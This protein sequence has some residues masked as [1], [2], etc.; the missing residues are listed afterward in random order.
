MKRTKRWVFVALLGALPLAACENGNDV[1]G[2]GK[3]SLFLTDAPG[4]SIAAAVVTVTDV[5]LQ[6]GSDTLSES[7][8]VHLFTGERTVDLLTLRDSLSALVQNQTVPAGSYGQLRLVVTGAYVETG[9]GAIY[10]TSPTYAGLP[11]GAQVSGA[12]QAPSYAQSGL[13]I[14][15]PG[16]SLQVGEGE[17]VQLVLDFDVAQSFGHATGASGQW[18]LHPVVRASDVDGAETLAVTV[19]TSAGLELPAGFA[20]SAVKVRLTDQSGNTREQA[21]A[22]TTGGGASASFRYLLPAAGPFSIS[23]VA[24]AGI[25]L[26]TTPAGAQSVDLATTQSIAFTLTAVGP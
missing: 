2:D 7:S 10:A 9:S 16:G 26:Q 23:L 20:L 13:K 1:A 22:V 18:V 4:D 12:L 19:N 25:T 3:V 15:L 21:L 5:Y 6:S 17:N 14:V 8:R 11:S 24:P